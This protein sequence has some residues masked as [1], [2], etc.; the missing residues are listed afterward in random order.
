MLSVQ[1]H[2]GPDAEGMWLSN[3]AEVALG[4][5]RLSIIDLSDSANQ[6]MESEGGRFQ[7]VLNGEIYN[8]RE[9]RVELS[10]Y[11]FRTESDTEV[12]LAALQRWGPECLDRL[13]GMF[14]FVVFDRRDGS[15]LAVRDR[16][17]VKP[18][19][20][21][22]LDGSLVIASEIKALHRAGLP[23]RPD[24]AGWARYLAH[25]TYGDPSSTLWEGALQ[26]APGNA[27]RWHQGKLDSWSWYDLATRVDQAEDDRSDEVVRE[28]YLALLADSVALRLRA[29]V[30]VGINLSGGLDS[31]TLL[32][33]VDKA[34]GENASVRAFTFT[35]GDPDYDELPWAQ[36]M[37]AHT[38]HK[39]EVC[40]L[41]YE[42][43]PAL[44]ASMQDLQDEPYGGLPTLAYSKI[45]VRARELGVKVLLDGQGMD[46]QW[47]GYDYYRRD[48]YD[49]SKP[50]LQGAR[51]PAVLG[52]TLQPG[53]GSLAQ[54]PSF[55]SPFPERL[56]NLQYRDI[57]FTKI[58]RALRFN[59]RVSMGASTE[60]REPFLDHRVVELAFRQPRDRKIRGDTGKAFLREAVTPLFPAGI[61]EAPKRP[62]QTPQREWLRGPLRLWASE[63]I[64]SML[65]GPQGHWFR[66]DQVTDAWQRYC[67]GESDNSFYVWQWLSLAMMQERFS[68]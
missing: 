13:I 3:E 20:Y 11:P 54:Q 40:R 34:Q 39:G 50:T 27:M 30:E 22:L 49:A 42:E 23:A 67:A 43:V 4:H 18:L 66:R 68:R 15:L 58:P 52:D 1:T 7:L 46:E 17:G 14:S 5:R 36:R 59:D 55:P 57:R 31:A 33:M 51:T 41:R 32:A 47:A 29:D 45:F 2:R 60:L 9:L 48:D 37:M 28:E 6:P 44:A 61:S 10:D 8:Y 26:L 16:F 21:A 19:Y 38:H 63:L 25:G 64:D 12:L 62:L 35:T 65:A 53:F 24:E 56:R